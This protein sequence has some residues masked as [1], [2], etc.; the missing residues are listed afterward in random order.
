MDLE[1][2]MTAMKPE[3]EEAIRKRATE[4]LRRAAKALK[5]IGDHGT[6]A[7][8]QPIVDRLAQRRA[9]TAARRDQAK[10]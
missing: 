10:T 8:I 2:S 4:D 3:S 9:I 1:I 6:V 7:Q 5:S